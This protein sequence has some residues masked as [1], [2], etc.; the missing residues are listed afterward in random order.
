MIS[1]THAYKSVIILFTCK[2]GTHFEFILI[3]Y[4]KHNFL[5]KFIL[6]LAEI[7]HQFREGEI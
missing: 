2:S 3:D 5:R 1:G 7:T 4:A 6:S